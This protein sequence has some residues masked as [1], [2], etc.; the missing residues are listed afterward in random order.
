MTMIRPLAIAAA[1][2]AVLTAGCASTRPSAAAPEP[3]ADTNWVALADA[4]YE[5]GRYATAALRYREAARRGQQTA[6]SWFNF[7]NAMVRIERTDEAVLAYRRSIAAAPSF[8]RAHQNLAALL[9]IKDDLVGAA[10]H[11]AIASRLDST[12]AD[13]R[14]RLGELALRSGDP[15]EA[16]QWF[17]RARALDGQDEGAA[18]GLAQ[19][20]LAAHDT[21]EA[22]VSIARF[23]ASSLDPRA[24]AHILEADLAGR[25]ALHLEATTLYGS[26]AASDT[27]SPQAFVREA[28]MH[29]RAGK[30][31]LAAV[32]QLSAV[33][34]S[35]QD[36]SLWGVLGR[37]RLEALDPSG[38][39]EAWREGFL[40]GD[41]G[42]ADGLEALAAWHERRGEDQAARAAR[43]ALE[44]P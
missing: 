35:P 4:A 7:A 12:D 5:D 14:Y 38:A 37:Y 32:A 21:S 9:Q 27:N 39:L 28:R 22:D 34:R 29:H 18:S 11:Y 2:L 26:A 40:L 25:R 13:S 6:L 3:V 43:T 36:G 42:S 41:P 44:A 24:W 10:T 30:P 19:A 20:W 16:A 8:L 23:N 31:A 15:I 33:R 17:E 1:L